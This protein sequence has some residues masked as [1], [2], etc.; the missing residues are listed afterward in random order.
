[1]RAMLRRLILWALAGAPQT[2]HDAAGMD[3]QARETRAEQDQSF[4]AA[5]SRP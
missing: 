1:M 3:K 4:P 2:E 5:A